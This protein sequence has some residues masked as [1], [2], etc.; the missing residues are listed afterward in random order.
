ME[1]FGH[2]HTTISLVQIQLFSSL[3]KNKSLVIVMHYLNS[4]FV[5]YYI[6]PFV[7]QF[8]NL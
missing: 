6:V 1:Q 2:Y 8:L 7:T 3:N 4:S 5:Q